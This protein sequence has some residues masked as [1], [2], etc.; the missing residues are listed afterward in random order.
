MD[1]HPPS[2]SICGLA[3]RGKRACEPRA[4]SFGVYE[5]R[6]AR[7]G[8]II[9][10]RLVVLEAVHPA[11][12]A[13]ATIAGGPGQG[14]VAL[15]PLVADGIFAKDLAALRDHND[16]LFV[17]LRGTGASHPF[18]CDL[19]PSSQPA[20]YFRQLWPDALLSACRARNARTSDL[21]RYDT[22]D[23][24]DDLDDVRAALGY[25]RLVLDGTSYGTF[26]AL[27]YLRR[28]PKHVESEVLQG[29][30]PPHFQPLPGAP[31]GAQTALDDLIAK[32]RRDALCNTSFPSFAQHFDAVVRRFDRAPVAV[33]VKNA[34][35]GRLETVLLSKEVFAD[36]L[37]QVLYDPQNAASVPYVIERAYRRDYGPLAR[38]VNV[39]S[40]GL[41]HALD[42]GA[43]LSYSCAEWTPFVAQREVRAEAARSF[44]GDSRVRAQ[45]HAC[46]IWHVPPMPPH[47]DDAVRSEAPILMITGSDDPAT[48]PQ[49]AAA[50]LRFLPKARQ[51]IVRGAGHA[52]ETPCVDRA[53]VLFVRAGSAKAL[54][55]AKC[56]VAFRAPPFD[57][58]MAGWPDP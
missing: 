25:D 18:D 56:S 34:A 12:H 29:V 41:A 6:A 27:V 42:W 23:A 10:L 46:A 32:C 8:R 30:D 4:E 5:D 43:F 50:A 44:V 11:G 58:S 17:D 36:R 26:F 14:S 19:A 15:A 57:T 21:S 54:S 40:L 3:C 20:M 53:I 35:T 47:F 22:N 55:A 28:H 51:V 37:R 33:P 38:I 16:M 49:P 31:L 48:P 24:V 1:A 13:V 7:S 45:Q 39:V 52:T 9:S 2:V